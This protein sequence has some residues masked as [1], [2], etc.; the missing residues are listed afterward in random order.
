MKLLKIPVFFMALAYMVHGCASGTDV[1]ENTGQRNSEEQRYFTNPI[2]DGADPWVFKKDAYYYY[3]G[4]GNGGIYISKS[5]K[6]TH[7]GERVAVWTPPSDNWNSTNI[8]APELHFT[9]GKW[10]I[11]YAAGLAGPP[12]I[13]QRSGVLESVT[14]DPFGEYVDKGMLYTGD[15]IH[16]PTSVKWAIDLTTFVINGQ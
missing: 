16:D 6:L 5:D 11:Y 9:G 10:Y 7:P 15:N 3:C 14:D 8:W 2:A 12:F 13:H 4:S 1:A